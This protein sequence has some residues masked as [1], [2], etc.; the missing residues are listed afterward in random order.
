MKAPGLNCIHAHGGRQRQQIPSLIWFPGCQ[1]SV[2]KGISETINHAN[3]GRFSK[4]RWGLP[5]GPT[6]QPRRPRVC[7][8][9]RPRP[10]LRAQRSRHVPTRPPPCPMAELNRPSETETSARAPG[11]SQATLTSNSPIL[12][13]KRKCKRD[14]NLAGFP[15]R[16]HRVFLC[17][18]LSHGLVS[19]A[20]L[21]VS[22]LFYGKEY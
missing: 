8:A 2:S 20:P 16:A 5:P 19:N 12:M 7:R 17:P 4:E 15:L 13:Q 1:V 6:R 3:Y 11:I 21:C 10:Q 9:Q 22:W 14:L 18:I